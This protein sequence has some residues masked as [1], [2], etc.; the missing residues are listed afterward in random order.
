MQWKIKEGKEIPLTH[1]DAPRQQ[2]AHQWGQ[3]DAQVWPKGMPRTRTGTEATE[4]LL[5]RMLDRDK[6]ASGLLDRLYCTPHDLPAYVV[7]GTARPGELQVSRTFTAA[8]DACGLVVPHRSH[9]HL[10]T[11]PPLS[12]PALFLRPL[13]HRKIHV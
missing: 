11:L 7:G 6:T 10:R 1:W 9:R 5:M 2:S 4:V 13:C 3:L 12:L 8:V